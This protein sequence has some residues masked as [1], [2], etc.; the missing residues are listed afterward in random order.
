MAKG[1]SGMLVIGRKM[2]VSKSGP[3][4][5]LAVQFWGKMDH[6]RGMFLGHLD[7]WRNMVKTRDSGAVEKVTKLLI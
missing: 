7:F 5:R 3:I 1:T 2:V 6:F 4:V